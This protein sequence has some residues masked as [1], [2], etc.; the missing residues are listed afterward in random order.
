[1]NVIKMLNK[2]NLFIADHFAD[3][4]SFYSQYALFLKNRGIIKDNEKVKRLF[5]KRENV[6]STAIGKGAA[7]PHIFS[8]EFKEFVFSVALI[9]KGMDFK[10]PDNQMIHI[11]FLIM[12]DERDVGMHLKSLAHIARLVDCTDMVEEVKRVNTADEVYDVLMEKEK[13]I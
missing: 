12:S 13:L 2:E 1:M 5:I 9:K 11:I 10:A 3:T 7:A 4:D 6:Q 8:G